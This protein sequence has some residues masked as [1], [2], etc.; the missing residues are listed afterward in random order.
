VHVQGDGYDPAGLYAA[1]WT[2]PD[3]TSFMSGVAA[4]DQGHLAFAATLVTVGGWTVTVVEGYGR[5]KWQLVASVA[6]QV[7]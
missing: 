6:F 3:G 7:A 2:K 4:D 5:V 1:T